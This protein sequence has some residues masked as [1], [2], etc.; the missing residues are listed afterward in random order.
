MRYL[1]K[2]RNF[3]YYFQKWKNV[4]QKRQVEVRERRFN[5]Q[6]LT[7]A[8]ET[9]ALAMLERS[10][11]MIQLGKFVACLERKVG[12]WKR[13]V[14]KEKFLEPYQVMQER[15]NKFL[16][17]REDNESPTRTRRSRTSSEADRFVIPGLQHTYLL[18]SSVTSQSLGHNS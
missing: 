4:W 14:F 1:Y 11:R 10:K 18:G 16:K 17:V 7:A 13:E 6:L 3:Y 2:T 15:V 5:E 9:W 8:M 12:E